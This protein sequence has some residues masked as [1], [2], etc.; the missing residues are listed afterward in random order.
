VLT[1]YFYIPY[2]HLTLLFILHP[3]FTDLY[4]ISAG[5]DKTTKPSE[6]AKSKSLSNDIDTPS[7][8]ANDNDDND[9]SDDDDDAG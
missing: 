2:T 1:N 5:V 3:Y 7:K 8:V 9:D 6:T 4:F